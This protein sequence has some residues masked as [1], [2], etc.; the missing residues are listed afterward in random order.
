MGDYYKIY[1]LWPFLSF[2]YSGAITLF[3]AAFVIFGL[4]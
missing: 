3:L 4:L 1:V 2:Y